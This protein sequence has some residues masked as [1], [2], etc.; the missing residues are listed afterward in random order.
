MKQSIQN[1]NVLITGAAG[2]I[3]SFLCDELLDHGYTVYGID[4]FFRGKFEN[5]KHLQNNTKFTLEEIDLSDPNNIGP[6][7]KLVRSKGID[8]VIHL[9]A[10]NGTAYFYDRPLFVLDQNIKI[11]QNLLHAIT[12]TMVNYIVYTSSSEVYG[13]PLTFPTNEQHPI[14]LNALSDRDSYA[15]SKA[16][17]DFYI[18]LFAEKYNIK[19]LI[20]RVFNTYGERMVGTRYGQVIPEFITRMLFEE[21]FT[22]LGNGSNTRSFCYVKDTTLAMRLLIEKQMTGLLNLGNDQ[23]T[24]IVDLAR[25]LHV[26]ENKAFNPVF[27]EGRPHDHKRR[28]PDIQQLKLLLPSLKFTNL[29]L[30]LR[31]V[32]DFYKQGGPGEIKG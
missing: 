3:G 1:K 25:K 14:L 10:I 31:Q 19:W 24:S 23:E 7:Q 18:R 12:D 16:L 5:I 22:I 20:L 8:T 11:T 6:V 29:D 13:E 2:F 30:G 21:K 17:G 28:F 27:L 4:N 15:A 9:A 26:L 32:I